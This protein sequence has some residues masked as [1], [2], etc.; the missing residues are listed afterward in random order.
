[1]PISAESL[2]EVHL[3]ALYGLARAWVRDADLAQ[4]LTHRTFLKAFEKRGQLREPGAAR[5]W[6]ITILRHEIASEFRVRDREMAWEPETFEALP[7]ET[8]DEGLDP[9]AVLALPLALQRVPEPSRHIL[10]LRFQQELSYEEI[11]STLALPLGTVMS[12]L[13]RAK[14]AVRAQVLAL[15]DRAQEGAP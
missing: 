6:L 5:A 11:A 2:V 7:A 13:Y 3:D 15:C 9:D 1:M 8:G 12:R 10:L 14:A 4:D